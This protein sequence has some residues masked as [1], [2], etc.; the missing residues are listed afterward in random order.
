MWR[1]EMKNVYEYFKINKQWCLKTRYVVVY[2]YMIAWKMLFGLPVF[3]WRSGKKVAVLVN[4]L[5]SNSIEM[6]RFI[7][8]LLNA[9]FCRKIIVAT[10]QTVVLDNN[11]SAVKLKIISF[12]YQQT[13]L[14][15]HN[16]FYHLSTI[17]NYHTVSHSHLCNRWNL[18]RLYTFSQSCANSSSCQM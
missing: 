12:H 6:L 18:K 9:V 7:H 17:Y 14:N 4:I 5:Q 10:L 3:L 11:Y 1:F 8:F 2:S 13:K 16:I 15:K